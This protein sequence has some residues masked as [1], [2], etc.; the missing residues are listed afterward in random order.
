MGKIFPCFLSVENGEKIRKKKTQKVRDS[1]HSPEIRSGDI[2]KQRGF[3]LFFFYR[4]EGDD[5]NHEA[6]KTDPRSLDAFFFGD[7][8]RLQY[9]SAYIVFPFFY[10]RKQF[11]LLLL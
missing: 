3:K 8:G 6:E 7:A 4:K 2:E 11:L 5:L 1:S 9:G 10:F